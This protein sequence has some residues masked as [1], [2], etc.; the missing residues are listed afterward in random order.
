[1]L[2][3]LITF[4]YCNPTNN[5]IIVVNVI[6]KH[7]GVITT[8]I[9][10]TLSSYLQRMILLKK[11]PRKDMENGEGLCPAVGHKHKIK[12]MRISMQKE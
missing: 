10:A 1:M 7:V 6:T 2:K 9:I 5:P 8:K 12:L 3:Y 11:S 4:E